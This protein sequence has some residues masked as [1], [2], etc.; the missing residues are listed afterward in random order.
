LFTFRARQKMLA[1]KRKH[2]LAR[3]PERESGISLRRQ[4]NIGRRSIVPTSMDWLAA[5]ER[6]PLA[7]SGA[8]A[9]DVFARAKSS[10]ASA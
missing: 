7:L 2:L 6:I 5:S 10:Q 1:A 3:N 8:L 9:C 4:A